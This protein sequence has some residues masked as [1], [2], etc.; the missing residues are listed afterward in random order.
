MKLRVK[1][2]MCDNLNGMKIT[3]IILAAG[4]CTLDRDTGPLEGTAAGSWSIGIVEQ[5][6]GEVC[7]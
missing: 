2:L 6:Q 1:Q 4:I 7:C 3:Q 5:F